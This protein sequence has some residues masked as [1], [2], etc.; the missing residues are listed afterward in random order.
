MCVCAC[1]F[2]CVH[3][4]IRA[5]CV[6]VSF[7][8]ESLYVCVCDS[9][10]MCVC[11]WLCVCVFVC[12]CACGCMCLPICVCVSVCVD[13]VKLVSVEIVFYHVFLCF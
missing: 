10:R 11:V 8:C 1:S 4:M 5:G 12:V 9:V 13:Q 2:L 7:V 3:L 6:C